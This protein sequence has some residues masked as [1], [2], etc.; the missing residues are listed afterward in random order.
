MAKG[1]DQDKN[2]AEG[3]HELPDHILQELAPTWK[4]R[5]VRWLSKLSILPILVIGFCL[6]GYWLFPLFEK[7]NQMVA[8]AQASHIDGLMYYTN[9]GIGF[10]VWVFAWIFLSQKLLGFVV[11]VLPMPLK[12]AMFYGFLGNESDPNS[13]DRSELNFP[14][15]SKSLTNASTF[16]NAWAW[17]FIRSTQ[18]LGVPLAIIAT[19]ILACEIQSY[20]VFSE[21]G[22]F[23]S[24]LLPLSSNKMLEW[25]DVDK[26]QLG[27][28]HTDDGGSVVYKVFFKNG[29]TV[30]IEDAIPVASSTWIEN[31]ERIDKRIVD[32]GS[33]FE[34]WKWLS[35]DPLHPK[36]VQSFYRQLGRDRGDRLMKLLRAGDFPSDAVADLTS[37]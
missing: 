8:M 15:A 9:F 24:P 17:N 2:G 31:M 34:R 23:S 10:L 21:Q 26:V 7:L 27:C 14:D 19:L 25:R 20:S 3:L 4:I 16:V 35:R 36:C 11:L 12:G 29:K 22:Y 32:S 18:N 30:R 13:I 37:H 28:N 6:G 33:S 5:S 1:E